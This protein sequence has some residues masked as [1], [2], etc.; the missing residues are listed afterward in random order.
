MPMVMA[1]LPDNMKMKYRHGDFNSREDLDGYTKT[2]K[3]A[4]IS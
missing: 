3:T 4:Y 2:A 1:L